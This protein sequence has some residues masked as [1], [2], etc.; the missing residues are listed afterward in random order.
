MEPFLPR[1]RHALDDLLLHLA[2]PLGSRDRPQARARL[3]PGLG[4]AAVGGVWKSVVAE[5]V[6][7]RV[8]GGCVGC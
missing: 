3:C 4:A 2:G 6:R 5:G 1:L 7:R 8:G